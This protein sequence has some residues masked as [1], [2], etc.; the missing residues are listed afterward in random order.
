MLKFFIPATI[1]SNLAFIMIQ[2]IPG[3]II[4]LFNSSGAGLLVFVKNG[5]RHVLLLGD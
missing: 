1:I 4:K 3:P 5:L 2:T